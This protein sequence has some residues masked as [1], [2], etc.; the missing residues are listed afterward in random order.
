[1]IITSYFLWNSNKKKIDARCY[2]YLSSDSRL[3]FIMI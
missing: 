3:G 2:L 1:M